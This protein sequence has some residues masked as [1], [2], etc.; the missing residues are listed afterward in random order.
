MKKG[1]MSFFSG[2]RRSESGVKRARNNVKIN[3][4]I[5]TIDNP[6]KI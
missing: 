6:R 2:I 4:F 5:K 1:G 3:I